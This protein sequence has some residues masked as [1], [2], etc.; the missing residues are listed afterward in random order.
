MLSNSLTTSYVAVGIML[1]MVV[2]TD[3]DSGLKMTDTSREFSPPLTR[4]MTIQEVKGSVTDL[5]ST[6]TCFDCA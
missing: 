5:Q 2:K 3:A 4:S 1:E 6:I